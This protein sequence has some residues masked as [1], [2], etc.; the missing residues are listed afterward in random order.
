MYFINVDPPGVLLLISEAVAAG[1]EY[2]YQY[3]T[4]AEGLMVGIVERYLAEY[5]PLLR[6]RKDCHTALMRI[7][8]VFVRVGWPSAHQLTYQLSDIYR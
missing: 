5:R 8:D 3:E 6:E 2:G 4:L 1:N 7:L